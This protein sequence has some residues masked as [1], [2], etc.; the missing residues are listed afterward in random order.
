MRRDAAAAGKNP[1]SYYATPD[2]R[3]APL[4]RGTILRIADLRSEPANIRVA[5]RR[6]TMSRRM[7]EFLSAPRRQARGDGS[8]QQPHR[9]HSRRLPAMHVLRDF[10]ER[11]PKGTSDQLLDRPFHI[12]AA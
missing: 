3:D 11:R 12:R 5:V 4:V 2:D 8:V 7:V 1:V 6:P 9:H 10:D